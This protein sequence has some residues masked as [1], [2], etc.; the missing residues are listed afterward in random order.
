M[1]ELVAVPDGG[2]HEATNAEFRPPVNVTRR[3][4]SGMSGR[5]VKVVV[6]V[7][8]STAPASVS[9][10]GAGNTIAI[11]GAVSAPVR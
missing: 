7:A 6:L 2:E 11:F 4:V 8:M 5:P 1:S 3:S 10:N 9:A